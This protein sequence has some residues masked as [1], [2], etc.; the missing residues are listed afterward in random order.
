MAQGNGK[1]HSVQALGSPS[2]LYSRGAADKDDPFDSSASSLEYTALTEAV[3]VLR[4]MKSTVITPE[5]S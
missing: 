1:L 5:K 3:A 4:G 2:P